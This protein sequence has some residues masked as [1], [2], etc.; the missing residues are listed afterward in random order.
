MEDTEIVNISSY[1]CINTS[2][3]KNSHRGDSNSSLEKNVTNMGEVNIMAD[4]SGPEIALS[5]RGEAGLGLK[6]HYP[7]A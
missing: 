6:P 7:I 3:A 1:V 2:I 5:D 4:W